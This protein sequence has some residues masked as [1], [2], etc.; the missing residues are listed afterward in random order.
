MIPWL[1]VDPAAELTVAGGK[2][3]VAKLLAQLDAADRAGVQLTGL[4]LEPRGDNT[5]ADSTPET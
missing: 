3:S 1:A 2:Q 5:E 4:V